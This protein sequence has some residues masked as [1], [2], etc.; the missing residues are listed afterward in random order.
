MK[1]SCCPVALFDIQDLKNNNFADMISNRGIAPFEKQIF[2]V[3]IML[4]YVVVFY[5]VFSKY[6]V[7]QIFLIGK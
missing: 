7:C 6:E 4:C 5:A 1:K 2:F 3:I